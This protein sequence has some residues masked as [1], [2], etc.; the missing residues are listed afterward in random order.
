MG[1]DGIVVA[2]SEPTTNIGKF[3]WLQIL[4]NGTRKW[5][6]K[7]DSG[8]QLIKTEDATTHGDIDFTG[9]V[10][11]NGDQGVTGEFDSSTHTIKTLKVKSG[12]VTELE[13]EAI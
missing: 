2:E 7:S 5:F 4:P 13:V 9:V 3:T 12:L 1:N 10:S 11:A 6:E 8:W